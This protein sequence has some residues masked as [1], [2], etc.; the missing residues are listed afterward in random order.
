MSLCNCDDRS[1]FTQKV[2]HA[3]LRSTGF[4]SWGPG[5]WIHEQDEGTVMGLDDALELATQ[6]SKEG[7]VRRS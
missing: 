4:F 3:L 2:A 7:Y 6:L 1:D 5:A